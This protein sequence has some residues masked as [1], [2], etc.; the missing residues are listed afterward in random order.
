ME[1]NP[2]ASSRNALPI[3]IGKN[4]EKS[5][6]CKRILDTT[7]DMLDSNDIDNETDNEKK[8]GRPECSGEI[9]CYSLIMLIVSL[10]RKFNRN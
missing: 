6:N 4:N 8:E 9:R 5:R 2:N 10:D 7:A 1:F 3:F